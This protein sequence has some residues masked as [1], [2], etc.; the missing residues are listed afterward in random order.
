MLGHLGSMATHGVADGRRRF[1]LFTPLGELL[2]RTS[3]VA[4]V[5]LLGVSSLG[6][7]LYGM[8]PAPQLRAESPPQNVSQREAEI[9]RANGKL[10]LLS[11]NES[12]M[13]HVKVKLQDEPQRAFTFALAGSGKEPMFELLR[14][15]FVR[16]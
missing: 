9:H 2:M 6:V 14:E 4:V 16:I 7:A 13:H 1:I 5:L 11:V 3:H 12:G 10:T 8:G 15:A